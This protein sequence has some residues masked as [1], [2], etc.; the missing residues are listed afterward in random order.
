MTEHPPT[1]P[2]GQQPGPGDD[3]A[4][5][6]I[7]NVHLVA[8]ADLAVT[9]E[10]PKGADTADTTTQ[11]GPERSEARA[12]DGGQVAVP[13]MALVVDPI[14]ITV[15]KPD[16][17][18]G[19]VLAWGELSE[20]STAGN[21]VAPDGTPSLLL[22]VVAGVRT[23]RF[24][25]PTAYEGPLQAALSQVAPGGGGQSPEQVPA[26]ERTK[27]ARRIALAALGVLVLAAIALVL[28]LTVG[29]LKL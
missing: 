10:P 14:G 18:V 9:P 6:T 25:V 1:Q 22:E 29:G 24:L 28:A 3:R 20:V 7:P 26:P 2:P 15:L 21:A 5:L 23:H 13:G 27:G 19:A 12:D 8:A 4:G 11:E 17:S 16:G